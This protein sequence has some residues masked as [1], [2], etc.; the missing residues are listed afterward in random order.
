MRAAGSWSKRSCAPID[1]VL[2]IDGQ[3]IRREA[4]QDRR[5]RLARLVSKPKGK[6]AQAVASGIVLSEA[7]EAKG[8]AMF[9]HACRMGL[10][11]ATGMNGLYL[12]GSARLT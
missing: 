4:V 9:R 3:E 10:E 2:E 12:S 6:A 7:I 11:G 8:E 5:K 1:D